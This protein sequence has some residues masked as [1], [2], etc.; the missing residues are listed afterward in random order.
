H[1]LGH[2]LMAR[3]YDLRIRGI[4]LFIFGGVAEMADEP[5]SPRAEFM[6]AIAGPIVS[7]LI[8]I[9]CFGLD[10]VATAQAWP[11]PVRGVLWYLGF[12][13]LLV[14]GFNLVPAFPLDGGRVLRSILWHIKG[15][16]KWATRI[17]STIGSGFGLLLILMGVVSVL[18]GNFIGGMWWF[19]IGTFLR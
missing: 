1:E 16:L 2:A 19:L 11:V 10:R 12:I 6:V 13:N 8:A 4:T 18:G 9:G 7:V 3:R 5:R 17:T 15:N 14:V